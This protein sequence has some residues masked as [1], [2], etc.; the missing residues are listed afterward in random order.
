[1]KLRSYQ[2]ELAA[3]AAGS[4]NV[5]IQADTG[6]GKTPIL[7]QIAKKN[8]HIL[9]I[10]HRNILIKQASKTLAR[11]GIKHDVIATKHTKRLCTLEHRKLELGD[12][13]IGPSKKYVCSIDSLLSR[14]RR[15]RLALDTQLPFVIIVD[16]AHHM[17]D[18]NKWGKLTKIFPNARI[19]GATATPCRLDQQSLARSKEGVFDRLIQASE[20]ADDST[21]ILIEKGF[22][23]DFKCYSIKE[24][25]C[26]DYLSLGTHDFTYK[27]LEA[28]TRRVI[29]EMTGDAIENYKRLADGTQALAFCVSIDIAI[30]TASYFKQ[31]GISA[32]A[33]HS[34]MSTVEVTRVFDLFERKHIKVLCNV[35]MIGEG[36]DVPAIETLIMLRK[37]ASFGMYRQWIGRALRP[38]A[39]KR[40]AIIIDHVGNIRTHDLPDKHIAWS[41]ENPP[42]AVK[43]NL[44]PCPEC[45]FLVKAWEPLCTECG[46]TMQHASKTPRQTDVKYLDYDLIEVE[47]KRVD[48]EKIAAS[49][50]KE[51]CENLQLLNAHTSRMGT[52]ERSIH[53]LKLWIASV[54]EAEGVSIFEMNRYFMDAENDKVWIK[55]F[56]LADV[57]SKND[58]KAIKV[59]EQWLSK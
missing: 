14:H 29:F 50:H 34:K 46:A 43:S 47:R 56:T 42:Q 25:I 24:R 7:A 16:E 35:D 27:T 26:D 11:F 31:S 3:N 40:H 41:L 17:V 45:T 18:R 28:E 15:D 23:S 51:L 1:M 8:K 57:V 2:Q 53:K 6:S 20:L 19:V 4:D 13:M 54:L 30:K 32:A 9:F 49:K 59:Y 12:V 36:V 37:T 33:I 48:L 39:S 5:L 22:L 21:R 10:A 58:K 38:D 44:V 52:L 55:R